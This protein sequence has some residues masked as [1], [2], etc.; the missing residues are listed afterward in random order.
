VF[1]DARNPAAKG[2]GSE[3]NF[4]GNGVMLAPF[5]ERV[6]RL[7]CRTLRRRSNRRRVTWARMYWPAGRGLPGQVYLAKK[8]ALYALEDEGKVACVFWH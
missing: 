7:W 6:L 1:V 4:G 3:P 8:V 5:R 2:G